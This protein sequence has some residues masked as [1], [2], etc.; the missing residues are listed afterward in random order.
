MIVVLFAMLSIMYYIYNDIIS[1]YKPDQDIWSID[2]KC[3]IKETA[4]L[5]FES[6]MQTQASIYA[7]MCWRFVRLFV[8]TVLQYFAAATTR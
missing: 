7:Y 5:K 4:G 3:H 2:I 8:P 6:M 1:L